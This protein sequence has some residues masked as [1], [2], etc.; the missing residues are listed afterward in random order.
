M[1][2][3]SAYID[4][5]KQQL[6]ELLANPEHYL[7]VVFA[8]FLVISAKFLSGALKKYITKKGYIKTS[9]RFSNGLFKLLTPFIGIVLLF[10]GSVICKEFFNASAIIFAITKIAVAVLLIKT[11][12]VIS[13]K[14]TAGV[15][16]SI[17][18]LPILVLSVAGL[19]DPTIK[20]LDSLAINVG[21]AKISIYMV[22]KG[23][24]VLSFLVWATK[25][26]SST[27]EKHIRKLSNFDYNTRELFVKVANVILYLTVFLIT[28]N[29]IGVDLTALAV[30]SG[31]VGVGIGLGLQ[32]IASNFIT[33]IVL[34][35]EK[36]IKVGDIIELEGSNPVVGTVK[37]LDA[38]SLLIERFDGREVLIPNEEMITTR[39]TNW[40]YSNN[41]GRIDIKI[42][43]AYD[44]DFKKVK[45]ILLAAATAH[46][47][48]LEKPE[49]E[50]FMTDFSDNAVNFVLYFWI[51]DVVKG[52]MGPKS[53]VM[54][55]ILEK[56]EQNNIKIPHPQ[57]DIH[58]LRD[59]K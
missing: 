38:R 45:E 4:K 39:V 50:C 43:V 55:S 5:I 31:A 41:N 46:P 37:N 11:V 47:L 16:L 51:E 6:L 1:N 49:P 14:K 2:S 20:Y 40:T 35:M 53:D 56:F 9:S 13:G 19:L 3:S 22:I 10:S 54:F 25:I 59:K 28:L 33:G 7:Q 48:S 27:A 8:V 44:S 57:M 34:L 17:V 12:N 42:G 58:F 23:I 36:S 29:V 21:K 32:K 24:F 18:I 30:L 52:R 15:F 26:I